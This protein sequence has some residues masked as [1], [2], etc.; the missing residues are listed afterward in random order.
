MKKLLLLLWVVLASVGVNAADISGVVSGVTGNT[1]YDPKVQN[2]NVRRAGALA[3]WVA[4]L[5]GDD[6]YDKNN[7]YHGFG[8]SADMTTLVITG[9]LNADDFAALSSVECAG[10]ARFPSIDL[11]GVTLA[12]GTTVDDVIAMDFRPATFKKND[13]TLSGAG[14]EYIRLPNGMTDVTDMYSLKTGDG[15][16]SNL[17]VVGAYAGTAATPDKSHL[18]AY[19][20]VKGNLKNFSEKLFI[21]TYE[22][23][24]QTHTMYELTGEPHSNGLQK[25]TLGGQIAKSD[26]A[27]SETSAL[28][29]STALQDFDLTECFFEENCA[30]NI[31]STLSYGG[32]ENPCTGEYEGASQLTCTNTNALYY[33]CLYEP[34]SVIMPT[35]LSEIPPCTFNSNSKTRLLTSITFPEGANYTKVGFE[36]FYKCGLVQFKMPGTIQEV[37]EGAFGSMPNMTDFTMEACVT[38]CDFKEQTFSGSK[39]IKHVTLS[40]GVQDVS[41]KMF[42]QCGSLEE[43]RIP[44]SCTRIDSYAFALCISLHSFTVPRNVRTMG[45]GVISNAGVK[46]I[47]LLAETPEEVPLIYAVPPTGT[48]PVGTFGDQNINGNNTDPSKDHSKWKKEGVDNCHVGREEALTWYQEELSGSAGLGTGNCLTLL[49]F[50]DNMRDFYDS[51][52]TDEEFAAWKAEVMA[53]CADKDITG[54]KIKKMQDASNGHQ[55]LSDG[56]GIGSHVYDD[57]FHG[58][59]GNSDS[60]LITGCDHQ[61]TCTLDGCTESGGVCS[62]DCEECEELRAWPVQS[63]YYIR[64]YAGAVG[65]LD[66]N[67]NPVQTRI[68]WRQFP[69]MTG[70]VE[71]EKKI[72]SKEYDDTWYTMCFPWHLTDNQLFEAFNQKCEITEFVGAE[73]IEQPESKENDWVYALVFHFDDVAKTYYMDSDDNYYER[74]FKETREVDAGFGVKFDKNFYTYWLLDG[75]D[76]NRVGSYV[77]DVPSTY[78]PKNH[79]AEEG[80]Q[81]SLYLSIKNIIPLA[82]HPYMIHPSVGAAPGNPTTCNFVSVE[83]RIGTPWTTTEQAV[84][85]IATIDDQKM[86]SGQNKGGQTAFVNPKTNKAGGSYT[87]IGNVGKESE[88]DAVDGNGAKVMPTPSYFLAVEKT[89]ETETIEVPIFSEDT[90]D[91]TDEHGNPVYE[92]TYV[93]TGGNVQYEFVDDSYEY[94]GVTGG[95]YKP[96]AFE[97]VTSGTGSYDLNLNPADMVYDANGTFNPTAFTSVESGTGSYV[98]VPDEYV[99]KGNGQGNYVVSAFQHVDD[100][101]GQYN[102]NVP[103]TYYEYTGNSNYAV[104]T[105]NA[106][107]GGAYIV[108]ETLYFFTENADGDFD[109]IFE[110]SNSEEAHYSQDANGKYHYNQWTGWQG[111]IVTGYTPNASGTGNF[112]SFK[113]YEYVGAG[114][115]THDVTFKDINWHATG[116]TEHKSDL[117]YNGPTGYPYKATEWTAQQYGDWDLVP[118]HY[119]YKGANQG[120]FTPSAFEK[121][122]ENVKGTYKLREGA[123]EYVYNTN[124]TGDFEPTTFVAVTAGTGTYRF[125]PAHGTYTDVT[126]GSGNYNKT[127]KTQTVITQ[128]GTNTIV[129]EV[130]AK[131][132]KYYRKKQTSGNKWSQYTAIIKPDA[133]AIANIEDFLDYEA[134]A[135]GFNVAIGEWEEVTPTAI[136]EI[137]EEAERNNEPV[138]KIHLNVVYNVKGQ[139]VRTGNTSLEGLPKGLYIV[140]GKKYMVK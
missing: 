96:S 97:T 35:T 44:N 111:Y 87:F 98:Y 49:H 65:Y 106:V 92:Y 71:E 34:V 58:N 64:R 132:P 53:N 62:E 26:L 36:A 22:N 14:A 129:R 135:N 75:K 79:T 102:G 127:V 16:N 2:M 45:H 124:G 121:V 91:V 93:G 13:E 52:G 130:Y 19:S 104:D 25:L 6:N 133:V 40:E 42:N 122:A 108:K 46:D 3:E 43:I 39:V 8:G 29:K 139:V 60:E 31:T 68:A 59:K 15:R 24:G 140:N 134:A 12:E 47:F 33:M 131:Y 56:Y 76:G 138:Q 78:D 94:V 114:N 10:F 80:A 73:L 81:H 27:E 55:W 119:E 77:E 115:G 90:E 38:T 30:V 28:F 17:K 7:P 9:T 57:L 103:V 23:G 137:L 61:H 70:V 101:S 20:F 110:A 11:S 123:D 67:D 1:G 86:E 84:T 18:A 113:I 128:T 48:C 32:T 88:S 74:V 66:E 85:K 99:Y 41:Y 105:E 82:G 69:L 120:D 83:E 117:Q 107:D 95:D 51:I 5:S 37:G 63:D 100:N 126:D 72:F 116:Y 21:E 4:A 112:K 54:Y 50:P 89:G 136:E 109:G 125:I 118:A